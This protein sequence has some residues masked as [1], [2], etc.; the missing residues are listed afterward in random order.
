[1]RR[2]PVSKGFE[3]HPVRRHNRQLGRR[4]ILFKRFRRQKVI[5]GQLAGGARRPCLEQAQPCIRSDNKWDGRLTKCQT[6]WDIPS[7]HESAT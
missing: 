3:V 6:N 5:R 4:D 7:A 1:M 2:L